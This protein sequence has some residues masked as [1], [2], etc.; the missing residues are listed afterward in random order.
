MEAFNRLS[1][2]EVERLAILAEEAAEVVQIVGKILR[3][4][5]E[6]Y[7]P[8][9]DP[10]VYNRWLLEKEVGHVQHAMERMFDAGDISPTAVSGHCEQKRTNIGKWLHHQ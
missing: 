4:G 1:P 10:H 3:H 8:L 5:Y 9:S 7:N 2:T 6:S